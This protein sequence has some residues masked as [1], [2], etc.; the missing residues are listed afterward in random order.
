[1]V[2]YSRMCRRRVYLQRDVQKAWLFTVRC[3][4]G[5]IFYS[6]MCRMHGYLQ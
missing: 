6:K 3:V 2:I 5:I 1:M 4:E